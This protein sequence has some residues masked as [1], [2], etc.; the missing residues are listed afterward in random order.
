MW[1][2]GLVSSI[3]DSNQGWTT[4]VSRPDVVMPV[5]RA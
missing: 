3:F 2:S 4:V 1:R 5:L